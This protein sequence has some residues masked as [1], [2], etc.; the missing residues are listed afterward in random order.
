RLPSLEPLL[1]DGYNGY[2]VD[3]NDINKI[4]EKIDLLLDDNELRKQMSLNALKKAS[5]FVPWDDVCMKH[6]NILKKLRIN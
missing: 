2:Y 5:G 4:T 3:L 6:L 1:D